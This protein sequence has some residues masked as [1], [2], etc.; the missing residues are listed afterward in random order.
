MA[1]WLN[2]GAEILD[3]PEMEVD[4]WGTQYGYS[5]KQQIQLEKKEDMKR[6]GPASQDLGDALA[7]SFSVTVQTKLQL[8]PDPKEARMQARLSDGQWHW[9]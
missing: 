1:D 7:M 6:R 4:L 8:P 2:A 9:G 3:D 5:S